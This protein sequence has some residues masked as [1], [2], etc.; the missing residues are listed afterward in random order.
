MLVK[1]L[2]K[3]RIYQQEDIRLE[4]PP[5]VFH[6]GFFFS[7][8]LLL[9]YINKF[10]LHEKRVVELGAGS[11][12][13]AM[14]VA[15]KG[16]VVTATDI[17]PIAIEYLQKNNE[18][19]KTNLEIIESDLFDNITHRIFDFIVINPPYYKKQPRSLSDHAWFCGEHGE[20]FSKLFK[21]LG[22]YIHPDTK[23]IMVLC[24]GCDIDMIKKMAAINGFDLKLML[25]KQNLLEKNFIYQIERS[26]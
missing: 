9:Q 24:D 26:T 12:L 23:T 6:P 10:S 4:I 2:S 17:S 15:K 16:A 18:Q 25:T 21:Q 7:T 3:T 14:I 11:G 13:I 1:Y 19:N 20:Y 22:D 5:Q 8:Q